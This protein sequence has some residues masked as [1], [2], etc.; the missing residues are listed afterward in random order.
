RVTAQEKKSAN[1]TPKRVEKKNTQVGLLG[2][3]NLTDKVSNL[4]GIPST[5]A[6]NQNGPD[7]NEDNY[8]S[9]KPSSSIGLGTSQVD[10]PNLGLPVGLNAGIGQPTDSS[11]QDQKTDSG[12]LLDLPRAYTNVDAAGHELDVV[13]VGTESTNHVGEDNRVRDGIDAPLHANVLSLDSGDNSQNQTVTQNKTGAPS[14]GNNKL[15]NN[16]N[17]P[18]SVNAL[19]VASGNNS[20]NGN[21][22]QTESGDGNHSDF[23][24]LGNVNTP[25][26]FNIASVASG[27]NSQN[28]NISQ[29]TKKDG[30]GSNF[31]LMD[32]LNIPINGHITS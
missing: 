27:N 23:G 7:S 1:D 26:N 25:I 2:L 14:S 18:I 15:L 30:N 4:V 8:E 24:V 11:N 31:R 28:G 21:I 13:D 6:K 12:S 17:M 10:L 19:S 32:N 9:S 20:Q 29:T 16:V 5:N 3:S 22:S